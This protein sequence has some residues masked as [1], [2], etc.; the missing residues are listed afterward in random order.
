MGNRPDVAVVDKHLRTAVVEDVAIPRK[1]SIRKKEHEKLIQTGS[2]NPAMDLWP[3]QIPGETSEISI[4]NNAT[5]VIILYIYTHT[6]T[7]THT[8]TRAI[9]ENKCS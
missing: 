5:L 9:L 3:Q 1:G 6:H 4:Q 8:H 2:C 7:H